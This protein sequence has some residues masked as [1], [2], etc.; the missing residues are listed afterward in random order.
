[1][2][3]GRFIYGLGCES[4]FFSQIAFSTKWFVESGNLN[5][6][7]GIVNSIPLL[8]STFNGILTPKLY[9]DE[10]DPHL[11]RALFAGFG[12]LLI[13]YMCLI[14]LVVID[15]K[16]DLE[17]ANLESIN[18]EAEPELPKE[19]FKCSDIK[20]FGIPYWINAFICMLIQSAILVYI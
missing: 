13:C 5:F 7:L 12:F 11:G 16:A 9:G 1:M 2:L 14:V 15:Y 10:K 4:A 3:L 8:G 19:D 6:A 18:G 20:T 17:I